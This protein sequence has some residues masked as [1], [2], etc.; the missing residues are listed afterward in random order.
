MLLDNYKGRL[1]IAQPKCD[2]DFFKEGVVLMVKHTGNGAWGVMLNK[3]I[4]DPDCNL[5]DIIKHVGMENAM[6]VNAPLYIGGPIERS[7]VCLIH[8]N[9]WSSASTIDLGNGLA[10]TTD[11]S[12]LAAIAGGWGPS[13]YRACCGISSWGP[14]QLEGEMSGKEPWTPKHQWLDLAANKELV[15]DLEPFAQWS[16]M[17]EQAVEDKVKAWF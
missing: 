3:V 2:S 5:A 11:I 6:G 10:V 14:G 13:Q 8:S 4:P 12:I 7:R 1:L 15:F 17:L 9:D 16:T